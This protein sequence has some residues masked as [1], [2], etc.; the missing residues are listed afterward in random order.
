MTLSNQ[1]HYKDILDELSK[2][3][4]YSQPLDV[5]QFCADFFHAKLAEQ[6]AM[7][8]DS[9]SADHPM[10][11]H[12]HPTSSCSYST[13][14]DDDDDDD[15]DALFEDEGDDVFTADLPDFSM[16]NT[17]SN[18]YNRGRR[19][20]V[21]AESMTPSKHKDFKTPVIAK[22]AEQQKR[23]R[24]AI[25]SNFLFKSLDENQYEDVVN[26]MN[27]KQ[28]IHDEQVIRQGAVGDYFYIVEAG[29]LDCYINDQKVASYGPGGSFGELALMYNSP[30][31]ATIVATSSGIL[32][33]LDRIT[34]RRILME[35]TSRKRYMYETFL[36]E[37]PILQSLDQYERHKIAD[38]LETVYFEEG[39]TV[40]E[41]GTVGENFY[42]IEAGEAGVYQI[43]PE[44]GLQRQI[45]CLSKGAY[46]GELALLNNSPRAATVIAHGRLRCATLGK[47]GFKRLL[48]PIMDIL[49]RNS[50]NYAKVMSSFA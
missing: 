50:E 19:T 32:W 45:N 49:K 47:R 30:R 10:E 23:I 2:A 41:Q 48:G 16:Y 28:I 9:T 18:N 27:E 31:A 44:T 5:L 8:H 14:D 3:V 46:F 22:T 17:N 40:I 39:Q 7:W 38:A 21:S 6:R 29:T 33:A 42:L 26:A 24:E 34:F 36:A 25:A 1:L 43:D 15:D 35:N 4:Q 37:V 12:L 20:S 13:T 11:D